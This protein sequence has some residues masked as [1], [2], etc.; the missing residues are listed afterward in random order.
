MQKSL[1]QRPSA[2]RNQPSRELAT[3]AVLKG[4]PKPAALA[5]Q[6]EL[7]EMWVIGSKLWGCSLAICVLTR[8]PG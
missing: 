2:L 3:L 4:A 5:A 7:T 8:L 1:A 6:G